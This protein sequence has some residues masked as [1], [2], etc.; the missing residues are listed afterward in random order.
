VTTHC[1]KPATCAEC[2]AD[3]KVAGGVQL[4][5]WR[6]ARAEWD[7]DQRFP[8]R[9][10]EAVVDHP[11]AVHWVSRYLRSPTT[12]QSLLIVGPTGTGKTWQA[13]GA[14]RAVVCTAASPTWAATTF[15]DFTAAL[16]PS[17]RDPAAAMR[18][19]RDANLL[20]L[21]DLGA[22]KS[23][24]WVEETTY[25]LLNHRYEA[26][27]PSIFTTNLPLAELR[28]GLGDRLASRLVEICQ[29]VVLTGADRRRQPAAT[30]AATLATKGS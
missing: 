10:R 27:L 2:A 29:R 1:D 4:D 23:S 24:E 19:Y 8:L 16:R 21:D 12:A 18:T 26:M 15:A 9:F 30:R 17:G 25:R 3:A 22:A 28:E 6:S 13:Y 5:R 20:L 14:L 11:D 7:C